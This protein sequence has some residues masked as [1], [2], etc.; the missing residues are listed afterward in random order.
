MRRTL[1]KFLA[2]SALVALGAV[3]VSGSAVA[4]TASDYF[5]VNLDVL[6]T[7][8]IGCDTDV[9]MAAITG[10]GQ[11]A[12]TLS[13]NNATNNVAQCIV[14][15]NNTNGYKMEWNASTGVDA[16][17]RM[18][19]GSDYIDAYTPSASSETWSIANNTSEWGAKLGASSEGY[20]GGTGAVGYSYAAAGGWGA[21]DSYTGGEWLNVATSPFQIMSKS[22]ETDVDG[23]YQ[24]LVFGAEV[25]S[26]Y[27]Q[28]TGTYTQEVTVT[29]T[30]L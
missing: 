26:N 28:P 30:T 27:L 8:S 29:A 4:A 18:E 23:E 10:T 3:S 21:A 11:S 13:G 25:G 5:P 19:S 12:I 7:I 2:G 24:Y 15:T 9:T 6:A 14:K 16:S 17:G 22:S 1:K 20:G